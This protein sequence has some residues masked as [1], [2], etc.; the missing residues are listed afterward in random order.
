MLD[1]TTQQQRR[2][3]NQSLDKASVPRKGREGKVRDMNG[4]CVFVSLSPIQP[5]NL[6]TS[7]VLLPY[8]MSCPA[9]P[10]YTSNTTSSH[11]LPWEFWG[12]G[13]VF[14]GFHFFIRCIFH[15][16]P[17]LRL[18]RNKIVNI[19]P[20]SRFIRNKIFF[21]VSIYA[22]TTSSVSFLHKHKVL[23]VLPASIQNYVISIPRL[24]RHLSLTAFFH[25]C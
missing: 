20:F 5:Q 13:A 24:K 14:F 17:F 10:P 8:R 12:G 3:G 15:I 9:P 25:N 7:A 2:R 21:I 22:N 23:Y 19:N 18:I 6:H 1:K 4:P 11:H 16:P